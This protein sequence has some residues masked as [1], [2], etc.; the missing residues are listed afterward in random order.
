MEKTIAKLKKEG[1]THMEVM[2]HEDHDSY[3]I[4]GVEIREANEEEIKEFTTEVDKAENEKLNA[5]KG[6]LEKEL[7][8]ID[9]KLEDTK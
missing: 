9:S 6:E 5:K 3:C 1:A 8:E 2:F 7:K 4:S